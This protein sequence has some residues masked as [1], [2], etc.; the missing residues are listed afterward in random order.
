MEWKDKGKRTQ[1]LQFWSVCS[2]MFSFMN[3]KWTKYNDGSPNWPI[4]LQSFLGRVFRNSN[5]TYGTY[6][7]SYIFVSKMWYTYV[8]WSAWWPTLAKEWKIRN[9]WSSKI[10][11]VNIVTWCVKLLLSSSLS[12][13]RSKTS[14]KTI[15]PH[16]AIQSLLFQM[17]VSSPVLKVVQ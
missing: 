13:D 3:K 6:A 10:P 8:Y 16:S 7:K 11:A 1:G 12:D 17:E 2:P 5:N 14:S 9:V 4:I 15:P